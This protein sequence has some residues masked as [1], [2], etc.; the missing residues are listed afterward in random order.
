M[1]RCFGWA[2]LVAIGMVLGGA[3][4]SYQK[5]AA[6]A[7]APAGAEGDSDADVMKELK[8]MNVHLKRIDNVL[9][10]GTIK[11]ITVMK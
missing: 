3:F 6:V 7:Q 2:M 5:T 9:N 1:S 11:V 8:E 4:G 10:S